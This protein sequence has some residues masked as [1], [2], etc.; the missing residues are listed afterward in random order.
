MHCFVNVR[1]YH[2]HH[3]QATLGFEHPG[4]N[5]TPSE[6]ILL[7]CWRPNRRVLQ[8]MKAHRRDLAWLALLILLAGCDVDERAARRSA[9]GLPTDSIGAVAPAPI[10]A[11]PELARPLAY[12]LNLRIDPRADEFVGDV[13]IDI[14]LQSIP[15][16]K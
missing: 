10:G 16:L 8:L 11:L 7:P 4:G 6:V 12:T 3:R 5:V 2:Y 9:T 14:E 1:R 13:R 15:I